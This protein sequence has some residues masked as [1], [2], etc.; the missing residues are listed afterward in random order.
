M[1]INECIDQNSPSCAWADAVTVPTMA[2]AAKYLLPAGQRK[3]NCTCYYSGVP[4]YPEYTPKS[5]C[6]RTGM[7]LNRTVTRLM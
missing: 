2:D 6:R 1:T 7:P 5:P 3:L 4:G